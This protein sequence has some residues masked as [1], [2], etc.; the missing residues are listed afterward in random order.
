MAARGT[1]GAIGCAVALG[2]WTPGRAAAPALR[3]ER[4]VGRTDQDPSQT[5]RNRVLAVALLAGRGWSE[6]Q[7]SCL[8]RLWRRE[9]HWN[10]R[11]RNHGSGAYG[12]PQAL[13]AVKM[14]SAGLDWRSSAATQIT[15]GLGYIARRYGS[16]C[17]AWGHSEAAGWY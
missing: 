1:A 3:T 5:K 6:R 13:P 12:I 2:P 16:P 8:D 17:A 9:S 7:W 14:R 11:A 4:D 10:H 15:W